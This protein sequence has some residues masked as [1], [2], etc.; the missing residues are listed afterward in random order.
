MPGNS[1]W[2]WDPVLSDPAHQFPSR[3]NSRCGGRRW[4]YHMIQK[5][6]YYASHKAQWFVSTTTLR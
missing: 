5:V 4:S 3:W 1:S 2:R 6:E